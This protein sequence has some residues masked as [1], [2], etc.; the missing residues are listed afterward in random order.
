VCE[1]GE[2]VEFDRAQ[3]CLR[4]PEGQ[5]ELHDRVGGRLFVRHAF[6]L[7]V[8]RRRAALGTGPVRLGAGYDEVRRGSLKP[9]CNRL[10]VGVSGPLLRLLRPMARLGGKAGQGGPRARGKGGH[11]MLLIDPQRL[12]KAGRGHIERP[13][14]PAHF[15]L[16]HEQPAVVPRRGNRCKERRCLIHELAGGGELAAPGEQLGLD[17]PALSPGIR[18]DRCGLYFFCHLLRFIEAALRIQRLGEQ[19]GDVGDKSLL[20]MAHNG[21]YPSLR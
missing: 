14:E 20:P 7:D 21:S 11:P 9:G 17:C 13:G 2:Q 8:V 4:P 10:E 6:L 5:P 3:K 12:A 1:R 18:L 19:V 15:S 16:G